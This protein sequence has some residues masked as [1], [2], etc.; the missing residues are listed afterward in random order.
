MIIN[1]TSISVDDISATSFRWVAYEITG[2]NTIIYGRLE[3]NNT[4]DMTSCLDTSKNA[5]L[6][7]NPHLAL[8]TGAFPHLTLYIFQLIYQM[9]PIFDASGNYNSNPGNILYFQWGTAANPTMGR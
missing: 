6:G 1:D 4:L 7:Y 8:N 9:R 3:F 5:F 2:A